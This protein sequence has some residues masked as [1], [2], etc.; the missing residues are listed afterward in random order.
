PRVIA[1]WGYLVGDE[2]SLLAGVRETLYQGAAPTATRDLVLVS[3][4]LG[5]T[6]GLSGSALMVTEQVLAPRAVD[7]RLD[8]GAPA[9]S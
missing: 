4:E 5:D 9:D 3:S 2:E 8:R 7:F 1:F 6:T